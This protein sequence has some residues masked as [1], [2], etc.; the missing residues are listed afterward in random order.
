M[1]PAESGTVASVGKNGKKRIK[2]QTGR[3][4]CSSQNELSYSVSTR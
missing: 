1:A 2:I 4:G 3:N